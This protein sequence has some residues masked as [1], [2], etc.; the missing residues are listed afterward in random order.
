MELALSP[1]PPNL[2]LAAKLMLLALW[3]KGYLTALPPRHLP[4]VQALELAG[5][6]QQFRTALLTAIAIG[7][8]L[9]VFELAPRLG[10]VL[11][12]GALCLAIVGCRPLFANSRLYP[13]CFLV[14]VGLYEP[15]LGPTLVRAQV[16]L[17]YVGA[18]LN[19]LLDPDWLDGRYFESWMR[20][21]LHL[22]YYAW[23]ADLL[24]AMLLSRVLGW[25]TIAVEL[26][27]AVGLTRRRW[28]PMALRLGAAFHLLVLLTVNMDFGA[29]LA[30]SL[31]SYLAFIEWPR[32]IDVTLPAGVP[33]F[34]RRVLARRRAVTDGDEL[35]VEVD[36]RWYAGPAAL[37]QLVLYA[38]LAWFAFVAALALPPDR[39][40]W[41]RNLVAVA[42]LGFCLP[43]PSA[44]GQVSIV[45]Q[46][47]TQKLPRT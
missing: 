40:W 29:F 15:H 26:A 45:P 22:A 4:F 30:A 6:P 21:K 3:A 37:Q 1:L 11:V 44:W 25:V 17:L 20:D 31:I 16:V 12:G 23:L 14:L 2:L 32:R 24:P 5:T 47:S 18:G 35:T 41:I 10:C 46:S 43:W 39:L 13:A 19:K 28:W 8:V 27:V 7:A 34:A 42:A 33:P 9:V 36:G 38:P